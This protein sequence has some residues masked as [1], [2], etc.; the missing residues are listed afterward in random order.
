[1]KLR[2]LAFSFLLLFSCTKKTTPSTEEVQ[3]S[4][5]LRERLNKIFYWQLSDELK[6]S[7]DDEKKMTKILESF[8]SRKETLILKRDTLL[9]KIEA[10]E[11]GSHDETQCE[12]LIEEYKQVLASLAKMDIGQLE[13]LEALLGKA[14]LLTFL[15]THRQMSDQ[16][17]RNLTQR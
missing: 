16:L 2:W 1:M 17:R 11:V 12:L 3:D 8:R 9:A 10:H 7:S 13:E 4:E 5:R 6:L 14:K 15:K